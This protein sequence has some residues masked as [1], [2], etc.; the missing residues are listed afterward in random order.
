MFQPSRAYEKLAAGSGVIPMTVFVPLWIVTM[1]AY[2]AAVFIAYAAAKRI[3]GSRRWLL[4]T[5]VVLWILDTIQFFRGD[6]LTDTTTSLVAI[7][8]TWIVIMSIPYGLMFLFYSNKK[9]TRALF[10]T[11]PAAVAEQAPSKEPEVAG[12]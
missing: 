1:I 2:C 12:K 10:E 6:A 11:P 3:P 8:N 7:M 5:I 9:V 4:P